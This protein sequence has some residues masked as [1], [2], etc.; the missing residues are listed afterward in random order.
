MPEALF[1]DPERQLRLERHAAP[2]SGFVE[3]LSRVV[4]GTG[5]VQYAMR[6]VADRISAFTGSDFLA[7]RER[8]TLVGTYVLAPRVIRVAGHTVPALYR[9]LLAPAPGRGR[10]GLGAILVRETRRWM[11]ARAAPPFATYGFV[12]AGNAASLALAERAGHARW[13]SFVAAPFT[14]WR[15]R[16]HSRVEQVANPGDDGP[17]GENPGDGLG[18]VDFEQ[19]GARQS[20]APRFVVREAGQV[21]ASVRAVE[22]RWILRGLGGVSGFL[23]RSVLSRTPGLRRLLDPADLRFAFFGSLRVAPGHE[24]LLAGVLE[25]V[26]ARWDLHAGMVYLD[27]RGGLHAALHEGGLGLL[28]GIGV[29]P[30]VHVMGSALGLPAEVAAAIREQPFVAH[31]SDDV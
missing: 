10:E 1:E 27:P 4:W 5:A 8:G 12:E 31:I 23:A 28:H 6:D 15:P 20:A 13:G 26:L 16:D 18:H 7:L 22:H 2:P 21:L 3:L 19:W 11:L 25:A 24:L 9:T 29:R 17:P 14:R 30:R